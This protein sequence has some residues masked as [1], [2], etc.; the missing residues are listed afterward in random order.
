MGFIGV[1]RAIV[2]K[3]G[4]PALYKGL[5]AVVA[6]IVPKMAIRFSSFEFFKERLADPASGKVS[7]SAV[8]LAGMAAGATESVL[9]VTPMV[10]GALWC[11]WRRAAAHAP[12]RCPP[13]PAHPPQASQTQQIS[14]TP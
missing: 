6:G 9:V 1:G 3:E 12:P 2:A 4:L 13:K 7:G 14:R 11:G 5:G 10:R 8:L